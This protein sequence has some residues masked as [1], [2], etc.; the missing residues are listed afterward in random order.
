MAVTSL[1]RVK[2]YIGKVVMYAM[3]PEKTTESE[4]FD[5]GSTKNDAQSTLGGV[6]SYVERDAATNQKSLVS[7]IMCHK[8]TVVED[9]MTVKNNFKKTDGVIAYH[10][11]QSFAEGE[12]DP[13]IAHEIGKKLAKRLWGDEYQVLITTHLD[14]ESHIHNHF[15]INTVG[16]KTGKKFHRTKED[17]YRMREESDRLCKEYGLS[18]IRRPQEKGKNYAEWKAEKNGQPTV[19]GA[20]REAIDTAVRG[21]TNEADFLDAMDQMGFV[22]DRHGKYPKIKHVGDERF[23]RF[24]SLG[25]GYD[26]NEIIDR[27]FANDYPELP[28]YP[29]QEDPKQIFYDYPNEKVASMGYTAVY[30][31]YHK[32]LVIA[33]ERPKTNKRIYALVRQDT[34]RMQSYS[35]QSRLLAKHHI[36]TPEQL[37][38]YKQEAMNK[39]D[40]TIA[41]RKDMRNALKRAERSGDSVLISHIKFNIDL[42]SRQLREL[43][44]EVTACDGVM[45]R[46]DAVKEKLFRIENEK[47]RGKEKIKDEHI[48]RSSR[49][50]REDES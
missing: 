38:A 50:D 48:S 34:N 30:H 24:K 46:V 22:I 39:I 4:S 3:N 1:W 19:R 9:M 31:C 14:K 35:D 10:G 44:S 5:T 7:G 33:K 36:E 16:Y 23:V 41:L 21:C 49:S 42:Y 6:V 12:V 11:Y 2:G 20:I 25:E 26:Y 32:A 8:D 40:E 15:V 13:D 29:E 45:E 28:R 37:R 43:R 18:V 27:V 17:Y 47:H